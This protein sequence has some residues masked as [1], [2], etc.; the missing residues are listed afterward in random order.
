MRTFHHIKFEGKSKRLFFMHEMFLVTYFYFMDKVPYFIVAVS[1]NSYYLLVSMIIA[2]RAEFVL[3]WQ[4]VYS[5]SS[6]RYSSL[7]IYWLET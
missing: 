1:I 7:S 4:H 5:C 2:W 6:L 3:I